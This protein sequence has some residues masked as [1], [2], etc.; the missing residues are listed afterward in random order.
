MRWGNTRIS[1]GVLS[2]LFMLLALMFVCLFFLYQEIVSDGIVEW[3]E[4]MMPEPE[5]KKGKK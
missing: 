2:A 1:Q 4:E 5:P 3:F